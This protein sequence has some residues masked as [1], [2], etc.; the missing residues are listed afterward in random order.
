MGL[1]T[2]FQFDGRGG[3]LIDG[4]FVASCLREVQGG[5]SHFDSIGIGFGLQE[6]LKLTSRRGQCFGA[7]CRTGDFGRFV[8]DRNFPPR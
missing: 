3:D 1:L 5:P 7:R 2:A 8:Q 6:R 4:G